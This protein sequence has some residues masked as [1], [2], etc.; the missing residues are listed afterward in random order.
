MSRTQEDVISWIEEKIRTDTESRD[1]MEF[2]IHYRKVGVRV[3]DYIE[4]QELI[5]QLQ[6]E[7]AGDR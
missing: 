2:Y 1:E 4:Y 7:V 6:E 3:F 5:E